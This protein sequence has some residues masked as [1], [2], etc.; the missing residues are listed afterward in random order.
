MVSSGA[1]PNDETNRMTD[2]WELH[3]IFKKTHGK[4]IF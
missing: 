1:L 2:A 4:T 3:S